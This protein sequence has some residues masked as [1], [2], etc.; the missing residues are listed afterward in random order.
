MADEAGFDL[1]GAFRWRPVQPVHQRVATAQ[2]TGGFED[3]VRVIV[4]DLTSAVDARTLA[5]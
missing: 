3:S 1:F 4:L 5:F 2:E